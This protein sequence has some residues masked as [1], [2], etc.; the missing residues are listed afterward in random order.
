LEAFQG[1]EKRV[2]I[3]C[4]TRT[5]E[6]FLKEDDRRGLNVIGEKRKIN[7]ALT[8]AKEA[9]FVIGSPGVLMKDEHWW[10]WLAFCWRN[11]LVAEAQVTWKGS[12][13]WEPRSA[14]K[15][16]VE[17]KC[18]Q[19]RSRKDKVSV[20]ERALVAKEE[21]AVKGERVLGAAAVSQAVDG[22]YKLWTES[23]R[24]ALDEDG[25]VEEDAQ[26]KAQDDAQDDIQDDT[27]GD[28]QDDKGNENHKHGAHDEKGIPVTDEI[29]WQPDRSRHV[30]GD[31]SDDT[32]A[33]HYKSFN[34]SR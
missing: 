34:V 23:L 5:R 3:M 13:L 25:E 26:D 7:V 4:T 22:E 16:P 33:E 12:K 24:E 29:L 31:A 27:Q 17:W 21:L 20:L 11:G 28:V 6:K 2:V 19:Y 32:Y 9:L 14:R 8:R 18:P 10:Q 1:L 30:Y 15:P